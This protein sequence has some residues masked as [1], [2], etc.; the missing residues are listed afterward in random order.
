MKNCDLIIDNACVVTVD[1]QNNIL[2]N[3]ALS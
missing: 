3:H 2:E 1:D